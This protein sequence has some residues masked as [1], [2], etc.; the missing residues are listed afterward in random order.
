M[1]SA[2]S[3]NGRA[4]KPRMP[5]HRGTDSQQIRDAEAFELQGLIDDDDEEQALESKE[6]SLRAQQNGH[7]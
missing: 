7:A 3:L 1:G 5:S 2:I 4:R 6:V